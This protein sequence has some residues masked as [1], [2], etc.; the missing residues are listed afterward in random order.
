MGSYV[1]SLA[2]LRELV[3]LAKQ[4]GLPVT[5]LDIRPLSQAPAALDDLKHGLVVGRVV[6]RPGEDA[7]S[8]G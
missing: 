3:A 1:G 7:V 8:T 6:L 5:P 4:H 2:E